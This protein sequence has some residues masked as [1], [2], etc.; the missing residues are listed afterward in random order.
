MVLTPS[1]FCYAL[2]MNETGFDASQLDRPAQV[3]AKR[4]DGTPFVDGNFTSRIEAM[5]QV[6]GQDTVTAHSFERYLRDK[7]LYDKKIQLLAEERPNKIVSTTDIPTL[8]QQKIVDTFRNTRA[9]EL[10]ELIRKG[11]ESTLPAAQEAYADMIDFTLPEEQSV[12]R[13]LIAQKIKQ[14]LASTNP[15]LQ[16]AAVSIIRYAPIEM[17]AALIEQGMYSRSLSVQR[18]AVAEIQFLSIQEQVALIK[19]GLESNDARLQEQSA[20]MISEVVGDEKTALQ[21]ILVKKIKDGLKSSD[22][23]A[24]SAATH[25]IFCAPSGERMI[26]AQWAIALGLGNFLIEP[27]LYKNKDMDNKSFSRSQFGKTGS[28]TILVGGPLKDKTIIRK[29]TPKAFLAWQKIYEDYKTWEEAGFDY[30]PIEPILSY[31]LNKNG[32]VEVH[33]GILDLS[34]AKWVETTGLFT[35]ELFEQNDAILEIVIGNE[36]NHGHAHDHNF[37]LR[38]FRD[39]NGQP[40]FSRVPRLYLIDFDQAVSP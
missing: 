17:R 26:L 36:I 16:T 34:L 14:G 6:S 25:M 22:P 38:F 12:L 1:F 37:C 2:Y 40:D 7:E 3:P 21:L 30:V 33:S 11:L 5:Y 39:E 28:E 24:Q 19:Q 35:K 15:Q 8:E 13:A 32:L 18:A 10:P 31:S 4:Q 23:E 27:P 9:E 29:I 20:L